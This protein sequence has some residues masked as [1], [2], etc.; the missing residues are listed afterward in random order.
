MT[1]STLVFIDNKMATASNNC[2]NLSK[3]SDVF[4]LN[5]TDSELQSIFKRLRVNQRM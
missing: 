1:Q 3:A 4:S 5:E 2:E